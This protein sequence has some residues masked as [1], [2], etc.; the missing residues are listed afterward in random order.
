MKK[1]PLILNLFVA[2]SLLTACGG[3]NHDDDG[4]P[5]TVAGRWSGALTKSVDSCPATNAP[6]TINFVHT[7]SQTGEAVT[8]ITDQNR[9]YL[10]N[11]LSGT[12]F[13]ADNAG[14]TVTVNGE[15]CTVTNRIEYNDVNDD[16]DATASIDVRAIRECPTGPD[17]ELSYTGTASRTGVSST[18][19]PSITPTIEPG[20]TP[21]AGGCAAINPRPAEG[22]YVGDG[23]CGLSTVVYRVTGST[24]VLEPF[25]ANGATSFGINATNTSSANSTRSDLTIKEEVGY[26]CSLACSAPSTFT[27]Q[28]F[29]EGGTTCVEKF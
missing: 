3:S 17:C 2:T 12:G 21:V 5:V 13:S 6:Q 4:D 1:Y 23:G 8:V 25:G 29:K 9:S 26:T 10:G 15:T 14:G 22:S 20:T 24:V 11:T 18:P 19:A 28:C 27:V 16:D 7:V